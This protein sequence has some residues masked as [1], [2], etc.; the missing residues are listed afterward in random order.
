MTLERKL[1]NTEPELTENEKL[2]LA[3]LEAAEKAARLGGG[4][5]CNPF[6]DEE[7]QKDPDIDDIAKAARNV[8]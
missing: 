5:V 8:L 1:G 4:D 6:A 7:K 3:R 2:E